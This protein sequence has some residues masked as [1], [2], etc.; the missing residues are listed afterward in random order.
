MFE[1][2][3]QFAQI[4]TTFPISWKKDFYDYT[5]GGFE[6]NLSDKKVQLIFGD[7]IWYI[8]KTDDLTVGQVFDQIY[9]SSFLSGKKY[10]L[11]LDKWCAMGS[12]VFFAMPI[13]KAY[14]CQGRLF[15][16]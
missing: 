13:N 5:E 3:E 14:P 6:I 1:E 15:L 11:E 9:H 12:D 16:N 8:D 7:T 4:T 2:F 10:R